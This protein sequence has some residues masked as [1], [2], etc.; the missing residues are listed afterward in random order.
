MKIA[1]LS[2]FYPYRGGISQFNACLYGELS[3]EHD[4]R[5]FNFKRQYPEFLFPGKTQFVTEDDE[6][7]PV[8]S[9][10]LLDTANPLSYISTYREIRDWEPDVLIVRYWMS[11]FG[12]SLGYVTRR[13]KKHCKVISILDNVIPHEPRFFDTPLTRYF[14]SGSTGFVTLCEAVSKDL[15]RLKPDA[16]FAVIQHPLYSHFGEKLSRKEAEER[17]GIE[18]DRK[19]ILFFGLIREYKGLDILIEAFGML[20]EG[21]YQLIIA[22]EPYGSFDRYQKLIDRLPAAHKVHM[23]LKYIKDSEVKDFFSAA[24][25]AVL[26]YRSATQSG[27]SSVAYHFEVP[28]IVTDVGG[29]KETIGDR[30]TG[31]V[32]REGTPEAISK[33]ITGFFSNPAIKD[34]CI[35]NIRMEKERLSW[36][37][38]ARELVRF[39]RTTG[40]VL[41]L[42]LAAATAPAISAQEY[43]NTPVSIS[44]EKVRVNGE[45]CYSHV[46]LERQT[47]F[48]ISKAYN[49]SIDDIYRLNPSLKE[50]GLIKNSIILIPTEATAAEAAPEKVQETPQVAVQDTAKE[51][52]KEEAKE[53]KT[54]KE[55][56]IHVVKW[57]ENLNDIAGKYGITVEELMKANGLTGKKLKS[58]MKLTIPEPGEYAQQEETEQT[59]EQ[60]ETQQVAEAQEQEAEKEDNPWWLNFRKDKV[61]ASL[62]LPLKATGS[63][64]SWSNMDFYSGVLLAVND[65]GQNGTDVDL[66]VHD[67]ADGKIGNARAD[68]GNTDLTIGPISVRDLNSVFSMNESGMVISPL[69]PK[70][71]DLVPVHPGMIQAPTPHKVQYDDLASWIKEDTSVND[72]VLLITEKGA[73]QTEAEMQMKSS[74]DSAGIAYNMFSYS[75]LEGRDVMAPLKNLMTKTGCNRVMIAS[76]SEAFVNDVV[77]NLNLMIH[78]KYE[79]VLYAASKIRS[80]ETIEVENLHKTN[81]HVSLTYYI[82]YDDQRVKSFL[83]RYRGLF[84]AEPS[85]FAFQGYDIASYFIE[86]CSKYGNRWPEMLEKEERSMLQSTF[87]CR[88]DGEGGYINEGVRRIV[89]E[90]EWKV[91]KVR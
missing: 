47:L 25:L 24:D 23:T 71:E 44:K 76:E 80:F 5:A 32:A 50:H 87:R 78:Q 43:N 77:R 35:R 82:D 39:I 91:K 63:S 10:S 19:N 3:K 58:R 48:S 8:E 74:V 81:L 65:L 42:A 52:V 84:N 86:M 34:E 17:L 18:H 20:P 66:R 38:F 14:L 27:I 22:G 53:K 64:S 70:A 46:V 51:E 75:I 1:I 7:V 59:Q 15:L 68:I 67:I 41:V 31:L 33:E 69:D 37:T 88:K 6:A 26:P 16:E 28:M 55:K 90:S 56:R 57:Y 9:T 30:G 36:K 83:L 12:P 72:K 54:A 4:V 62:L 21:E 45:T 61:S 13:M 85:Q 60:S 89:Y 29:L 11:Y 49:V 73:R 2:C 40:F 79:V